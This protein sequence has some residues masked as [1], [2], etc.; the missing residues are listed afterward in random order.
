MTHECGGEI[1]VEPT[2][3]RK[4]TSA[5]R[6]EACEAFEAYVPCEAFEPCEAY[7]PC[8]AF[9]P[10]RDPRH[11]G[12]SCSLLRIGKRRCVTLGRKNR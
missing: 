3:G 7:L 1:T 12:V 4:S 10:W 8:E 5:L 6:N 2:R 11:V 9:E